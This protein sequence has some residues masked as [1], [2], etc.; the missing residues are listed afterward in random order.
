[1]ER[2]AAEMSEV[3]EGKRALVG[4]FVLKQRRVT[5][6]LPESERAR[7]RGGGGCSAM[8]EVEGVK[9]TKKKNHGGK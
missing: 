5:A 7:E 6:L 2:T 8:R 3:T 1:M 9:E 4:V